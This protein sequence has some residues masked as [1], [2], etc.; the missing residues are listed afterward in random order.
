[1]AGNDLVGERGVFLE[2]TYPG[3]KIAQT[4]KRYHSANGDQGELPRI[5]SLSCMQMKNLYVEEGT[6]CYY[7][8]GYLVGNKGI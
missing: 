7:S 2:P 3:Q 5:L 1:M 8:Y 4:G 6:L